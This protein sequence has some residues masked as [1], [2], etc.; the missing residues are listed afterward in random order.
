MKLATVFSRG[1]SNQGLRKSAVSRF[2]TNLIGSGVHL[3]LF[4][5]Q[6]HFVTDSGF[7]LSSEFQK[8][9]DSLTSHKAMN[10]K[11]FHDLADLS[12]RR[13]MSASQFSIFRHV[14]LARVAPTVPCLIQA[15]L[16]AAKNG[17]YEKLNL[18]LANIGE[19]AGMG[20]GKLAHP[21]LAECAFNAVAERVY[22]LPPIT[23]ISAFNNPILPQEILYRA[24][25]EY[26]YKNCPYLV[27]YVQERFSGGDQDNI[28]MMASVYNIFKGFKPFFNE[29]EYETNILPYF[30]SHI[31]IDKS[32]MV[33]N[34]DGVEFIHAETA[35]K[36]ALEELGSASKLR[37]KMPELLSF[38]E[39]QGTL[40]DALEK[41]I[42]DAQGLKKPL[43]IPVSN[44]L[45]EHD[46]LNFA[47][48]II[49][50]RAN[51]ANSPLSSVRTRT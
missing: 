50:E 49:S 5:D 22:K 25:V 35:R 17:E 33:D 24:V 4:N 30:S 10:H 8:F 32:G 27:S 31:N 18:I 16:N 48:R 42:K 13:E 2:T 15:G 19:E 46:K 20:D 39:V 43:I 7:D 29:A 21:K 36:M 12:E 6:R 9:E 51:Q 45:I 44:K 26:L 37:Q 3:N 40:W 11:V 47:D 1:G 34:V 38:A 41:T 28:G 23:M 14:F